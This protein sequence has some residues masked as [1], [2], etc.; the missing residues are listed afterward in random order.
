[1]KIGYVRN[2]TEKSSPT[3][4]SIFSGPYTVDKIYI[5]NISKDSSNAPRLAEMLALIKE[6]D[7]VIVGSFSNLAY[8][9]QSFLKIIRQLET[10]KVVL[11]SIE[12]NLDTS[13]SAGKFAISILF[14]LD[15]LNN[16]NLLERQ[17]AGIEQAKAKGKYKG[18]KPIEVDEKHFE[19]L[20]SDW[21]NGKTTPKIMMD[22]L[23]LK[24][25]TFWRKVK[26]YR[27]RNKIVDDPTMK[28]RI[29]SMKLNIEEEL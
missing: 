28:K 16:E 8:N 13:T 20:Y 5:D 3:I 21:Q 12:E 29:D 10:K 11:V 15:K 27:D 23:Q 9:A 18:R 25:A 2:I 17:R 6:G 19:K 24:P 14:A 1:M 7:T 4:Y 22:E 26:D